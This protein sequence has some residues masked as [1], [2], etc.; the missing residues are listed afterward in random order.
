M[1]ELSRP[2]PLAD[3]AGYFEDQDRWAAEQKTLFARY[4]W[5]EEGRPDGRADAHWAM[6]EEF[7]GMVFQQDV[8]LNWD[9]I[10]DMIEKLLEDIDDLKTKNDGDNSLL[11]M[12]TTLGMMRERFRNMVEAI[13]RGLEAVRLKHVIPI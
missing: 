10:K 7:F 12:M 13:E 4:F 3:I 9:G 2:L 5:E 8:T 6:A 11:T 1:A